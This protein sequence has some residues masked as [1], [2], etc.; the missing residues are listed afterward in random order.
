MSGNRPRPGAGPSPSGG[1]RPAPPAPVPAGS[2]E[3]DPDTAVDAPR[4][5]V[6]LRPP[7]GEVAD[8]PRA[9]DRARAAV[10]AAT[11][12]GPMPDPLAR[13][14][15]DAVRVQ[16]AIVRRRADVEPAPARAPSASLVR[17]DWVRSR[18][19]GLAATLVERDTIALELR[20]PPVASNAPALAIG[21]DGESFSVSRA[22]EDDAPSLAAR[23]EARLQRRFEV[24]VRIL[25]PRRATVRLVAPRPGP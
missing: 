18:D 6:T 20:A 24:E 11:S 3:D 17:I 13:A 5:R 8:E 21:V 23:V 9:S 19:R 25:D 1:A 2:F 7:R 4:A 10:G 15:L 16:E 22:R 12:P 14:R